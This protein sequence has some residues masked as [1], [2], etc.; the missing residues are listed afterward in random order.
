MSLAPQPLQTRVADAEV[1]SLFLGRW[2]SRAYDDRDIDRDDLM[3]L[4]EAARWAASCFNDQPWHFRYVTRAGDREGAGQV[5]VEGNRAWAQAAPV[6]GVVFTR[7]ALTRTGAPNDWARF[8]AGAASAQMALRAS[9]LGLSMHLMAGFDPQAAYEFY[10][11][12]ES[13]WDAVAAFSIGY[14]GDPAQLPEALAEREVPS[15]RKPLSEVAQE[16]K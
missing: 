8:D 12:D 13:E 3:S 4:F 16:V 10:G 11:M 9:Q 14:P 2:S 7:R 1:D 15:P 5:M 6:L